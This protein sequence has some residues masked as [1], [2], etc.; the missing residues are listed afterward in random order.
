[1]NLQAYRLAATA[2]SLAAGL[3]LL[4][5]ASRAALEYDAALEAYVVTDYPAGWPCTPERIADLDRR[6]GLGK[7]T[8]DPAT[9]AWRLDAHLLI[10][11][12]DGTETYFQI[13]A[14]DRPNETLIVCGSLYLAPYHV[15]GENPDPYWWREPAHVNRLSLGVE[16][17]PA[18]RAALLFETPRTGGAPML[19]VGGRPEPGGARITR[20]RGG[21]LMAWNSRIA[22]ASG[23]PGQELQG[24]QLMG[25]GFVFVNSSL[26]GVRDMMT[27][28]LNEGWRMTVRVADSVFA[29]GAV[30]VVGGGPIRYV[31]CRFQSNDTA[32][33]DYGGLDV[34]LEDCVFEHNRRN[35]T[36]RF[37]GKTPGTLTLVDCEVG[38]P[39]TNN[40]MQLAETADTRARRAG[41]A[42][43]CL[44]RVVIQR[45]LAARVLDAAG[46]PVTGAVV[47]VRAEQPDSGLDEGLRYVTGPD[48][49]T[50]GRGARGAI[51]L[52]VERQRV[53]EG[54][55]DGATDR[56]TYAVSAEHAGRRGT[57]AGAA[58]ARSWDEVSVTIR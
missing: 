56:W 4:A 38:P 43:L 9:G 25:D 17:H 29:R 46:A 39:R 49:R 3:L 40:L 58:P 44:P 37:P 52:A 26:A 7:M 30:A 19:V 18:V 2:V 23:A 12:N 36:L 10:G 55:A 13:G 27:Y 11:A 57:V 14:P 41:G 42:P 28:G 6:L 32:V 5:P 54:R 48:G 8:R 20:G 35:W 50:P 34:R 15:A 21:Q 31:N 22:A 33:L 45:H 16:A 1:M 47:A 51:L 53:V 24:V